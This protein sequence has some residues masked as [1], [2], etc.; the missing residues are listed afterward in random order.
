LSVSHVRLP[1]HFVGM[2]VCLRILVVFFVCLGK[3][4]RYDRFLKLNHGQIITYLYTKQ[5]PNTKPNAIDYW[6]CSI[7]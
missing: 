7:E 5:K 6:K 2:S 1:K 4:L 3:I